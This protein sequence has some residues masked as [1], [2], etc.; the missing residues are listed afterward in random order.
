MKI[1]IVISTLFTLILSACGSPK[2]A[3]NSNF[4]KALDAHF[5]KNCITIAPFVFSAESQ[6]YPM[7]VVLQQKNAFISQQQI[8]Q[9]NASATKVLDVLV[10][11]GLLSSSEGTKKV[12]PMFGTT[13]LDVPTKVFTLTELGSKS[14]VTPDSTAM[15]VGHYKVDEIIRFTQ[16]DSALGHTVSEVSF[17]ASPVGVPDW[18]KGTEIQTLFGL[19]KKLAAHTKATQTMV[20]ASDGWID[21]NDFS[22]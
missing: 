4:E 21:A 17:T 19:E 12:K 20:L 18:A 16:P 15:C 6:K 11:A 10:K 2:D 22:K 8:D 7:T 3:N 9:T 13:E 1:K 5:E 14:I